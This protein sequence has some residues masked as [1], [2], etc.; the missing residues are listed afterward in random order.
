MNITKSSFNDYLFFIIIFSILILIFCIF[1][2]VLFYG[3]AFL[4]EKNIENINIKSLGD[5]ANVGDYI[6]GLAGSAL[7]FVTVML[8]I[9]SVMFQQ[10]QIQI[11]K[12]ELEATRAEMALAREEAKRAADA[13]EELVKEQKEQTTHTLATAKAMQEA[14]EAQISA[15]KINFRVA[16]ISAAEQRLAATDRMLELIAP[17]GMIEDGKGDLHTSLWTSRQKIV[18]EILNLTDGLSKDFPVLRD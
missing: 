1:F 6:G 18:S 17:R 5:L 12:A 7:N 2:S 9:I 10:R 16:L 8:L 3:N 15:N 13:N 14:A 11:S 4:W